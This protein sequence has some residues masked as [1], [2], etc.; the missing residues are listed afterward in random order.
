MNKVFAGIALT[1]AFGVTGCTTMPDRFV[2][3]KSIFPNCG[4]STEPIGNTGFALEIFIKNY[5]FTPSPDAS[6]QLGREC[7]TKTAVELAKRQRKRIV[8]MMSVDMNTSAT[9]NII[10]AN[11]SIYVTGKVT[12]A[13]E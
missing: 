4:Y 12:Y 3:D 10:D 9:R 6:I 7:F 8:P 11:Y 5:S 2:S 1:V 13:S